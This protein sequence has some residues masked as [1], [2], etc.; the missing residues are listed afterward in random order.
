MVI[1][2]QTLLLI[3]LTSQFLRSPELQ[4]TDFSDEMNFWLACFLICKTAWRFLNPAYRKTSSRL[5]NN[6][7]LTAL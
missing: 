4:K 5:L 3:L 7:I 1:N 6:I 2:D